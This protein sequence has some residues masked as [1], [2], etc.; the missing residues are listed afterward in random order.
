MRPSPLLLLAITLVIFLPG[1]HAGLKWPVFH[2]QAP[3]VGSP[4][5]GGNTVF[6]LTDDGTLYS[7]DYVSGGQSFPLNLGAPASIAPVSDGQ[8]LY[9]ATD[10]GQLQ[11]IQMSDTTRLWRYPPSD[12][13]TPLAQM[14]GLATGGGLVYLVTANQTIALDA[15]TGDVRWSRPLVSGGGPVGADSQRVYVSDGPNLLAYD[16]D[17]VPL[18]SLASGPLFKTV[19]VPDPSTGRVYVAT[20]SGDVDSIS[21][22]SGTILWSYP[23]NGWAMSSPS[24]APGGLV[25][26]GANDGRLRALSAATGA[27]VWATDTG[28]AIWTKPAIAVNG[29]QSIAI[30]GTQD[31][32]LDALNVSDGTLLWRY[33][34]SGWMG[35]PVIGPDG[36]TA[37]SGSQDGGLWAV[38]LSPMCTI[39][40]PLTGQLVGPQM[41]LRGRAWAWDGVSRVTITAG[42]LALPTLN[43]LS[44][45][46][47]NLSVD[48][49]SVG[50]GDLPISCLAQDSAGLT[51]TDAGGVKSTPTESLDA[52][53]D[54]MTLTVQAVAAPGA[55]FQIWVRGAQGQDLSGVLLDFYGVNQTIDSPANLTAPS[56]EGVY[57]LTARRDGYNP[58]SATLQVQGSNGPLLLVLVAAF[59]VVALMLYFFFIRKKK[60]AAPSD[61]SK[62]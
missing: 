14:M 35:S 32:A 58:A 13:S 23:L 5:V 43:L 36:R 53:R 25:I 29:N 11:A 31:D 18:W 21:A 61:Y 33:P 38:L 56:R 60:M 1:L 47:F 20:T 49:S 6:M 8:A 44:S 28:G 41:T 62:L 51:E 39:D 16:Q 55:P 54:N 59:L 2:A 46:P 17:G 4:I 57:P 34:T 27:L 48:L 26:V 12:N 45:G 30:V 50:E 15:S 24:P 10:D 40:Y 42:S 3:A 52:P 9:V 19:P 37:L 7:L 22:A